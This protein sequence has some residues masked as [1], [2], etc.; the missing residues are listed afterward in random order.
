MSKTLGVRH[1]REVLQDSWTSPLAFL[2]CTKT[3]RRCFSN[4]SQRLA[5]DD[6]LSHLEKEQPSGNALSE[7]SAQ[8][9]ESQRRR[10]GHEEAFERGGSRQRKEDHH[11]L[12]DRTSGKI[13]LIG[14]GSSGVPHSPHLRKIPVGIVE[15]AEGGP[16]TRDER[17]P[18]NFRV[19]SERKPKTESR[20]DYIPF[21][22]GTE[23][24]A[25]FDFGDSTITPSERKAFEG[26]FEIQQDAQPPPQTQH[27]QSS[28][29]DDDINAMFSEVLEG[30]DRGP[31][32]EA[33][34]FPEP[35]RP[36]AEKARAQQMKKQEA[37]QKQGILQRSMQPRSAAQKQQVRS[38]SAQIALESVTNQMAKAKTEANLWETFRNHVLVPLEGQ[39]R[40]KSPQ[41]Y[42]GTHNKQSET[43]RTKMEYGGTEVQLPHGSFDV[44]AQNLSQYLEAFNRKCRVDYPSSDLRLSL[45]PQLK[46]IGPSSF[47]LV[48]STSLYNNHI[49]QL[50]NKYNDIGGVNDMLAEMD[51]NVVDFDEDTVELCE[52][53]LNHSRRIQD[54]KMTRGE[55]LNV[56]YKN[57]TTRK[58]LQ[59]TKHWLH[60]IKA[61]LREKA[62]RQMRSQQEIEKYKQSVEGKE[63]EG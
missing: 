21:E 37:S 20:T 10:Q 49:A 36:L 59:V 22:D 44:L 31:R 35:L 8:R 32:R 61:R 63:E 33:P 2:Y 3:I 6:A 25:N 62:L 38:R 28:S 43:I 52:T 17:S 51:N 41:Q 26:L 45:L 18:R 16:F 4:P 24:D 15:E 27:E 12:G 53:I 13:R 55:A 57:G 42:Y 40:A 58:R 19:S 46:K 5:Q 60:D 1:A 29:S 9:R 47:A 56:I 23:P 50:W 14:G 7:L 11:M 39:E 34:S 48:A 54:P 30:E